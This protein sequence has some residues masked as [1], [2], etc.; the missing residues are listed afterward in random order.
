MEYSGVIE[1]N[2]SGYD[3]KDRASEV[4]VP[5]HTDQNTFCANLSV[6]GPQL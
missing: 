6:S 1:N 4:K 2:K 3:A 5:G